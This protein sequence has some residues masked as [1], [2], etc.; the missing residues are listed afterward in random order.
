MKPTASDVHVNA[1]LTNVSVA[2]I[3]AAEAYIADKVFPTVPVPNQ[4]NRYFV[5]SKAD[6]FRDEAKIRAPATE[7]AGGGFDLDNTPTYAAQVYALHKDVD[8]QV[9]ANADAAINPDRDATEYITQQLLIRR[10]KVWAAN[11]FAAGKW[12]LDLTGVAA[13]PGANQFLQWNDATSKPC[14]VIHGEIVRITEATGF[15][16]NTLVLGARTFMQLCDNP[17]V[18]G[19]IQYVQRGVVTPDILASLFGVDRVLV[20]WATQ[21]TALEGAAAAMSMIANSKAALLVY[22]NPSPSLMQPSGGYT[23]AWTGMLGA[24]AT[25]SRIKR[26][27]ME[28]LEADRIEGELAFDM[29][30]VASDVGTFFASAVA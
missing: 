17:D 15:K 28:H 26:F 22:A 24:G 5:Y 18:L 1:P 19:R 16:P 10:D 7:S 11:Y 6:F 20:A 8:D 30:L 2:Y 27:R 21:N 14:S 4:S 13:A 9:R 23:F 29:K 3:Q 12:G 25:G